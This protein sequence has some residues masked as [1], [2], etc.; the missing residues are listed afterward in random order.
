MTLRVLINRMVVIGLIDDRLSPTLRSPSQL[1]M[2]A[3]RPR[4]ASFKTIFLFKIN[5]A[6]VI[7]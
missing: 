1:L 6:V 5:D 3:L 4:D 7:Y 2:D